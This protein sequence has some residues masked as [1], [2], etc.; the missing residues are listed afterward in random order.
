MHA[1]ITFRT[2]RPH[3]N[4]IE[5]KPSWLIFACQCPHS[6]KRKILIQKR[7]FSLDKELTARAITLQLSCGHKLQLWG[8]CVK[9]ETCYSSICS[10]EDEC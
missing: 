8:Q 3:K 9:Y 4:K 6:K 1:P 10:L 5:I 2:K 7:A